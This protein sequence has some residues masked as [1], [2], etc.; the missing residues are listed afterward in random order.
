MVFK[1]GHK[2]S[3]AQ[4]EM[5]RKRMTGKK[6]PFYGKTHS[7]DVKKK[8][9]ERVQSKETRRKISLAGKGRKHT[10]ATKQKMRGR[11]HTE[12]TKQ[13]MRG[14]VP[15]NKGIPMS[16]EQ[17]K[18]FNFKGGKHTPESKKKISMAGKGRKHTETAKRKIGQ[19]QKGKKLSEK[20][21]QKMKTT[22]KKRFP[23][24][25]IPWHKGKTGVFSEE[26]L[27]KIRKR[28][29]KQILP[30]KNSIPEIKLQKLLKSNKIKFIS[31]KNFNLGFQRHQVDIF[32]EPNICI[33]VDG[34]HMHANPKP[35]RIPKSSKIRSGYNAKDVMWRS[36]KITKTAKWIWDNDKK[37][38]KALKKLGNKVLRLWQSEIDYEPEKCLK[39]IL[40]AIKA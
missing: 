31:H 12:A 19:A 4:K 28:R 29:A 22:M 5:M 9:R 18:K 3:E 13:K 40:K 23:Q 27:E 34:D 39:K 14:R 36:S 17:K 24:G 15:H 20:S 33:E 37:Q 2:I 38:T 25:R 30:R 21:I 7:E 16:E 32:I 26:A 11:K 1:K 6:N 8:I 35:H 10:E